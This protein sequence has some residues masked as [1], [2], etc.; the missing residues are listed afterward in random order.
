[1]G[2]ILT[3]VGYLLHLHE[4]LFSSHLVDAQIPCQYMCQRIK[5][6]VQGIS[7]LPQVQQYIL[8]DV[9]CLIGIFQIPLRCDHQ[10]GSDANHFLFEFLLCH[11]DLFYPYYVRYRD[12]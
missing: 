11:H 9:L 6:N 12:L 8:N 1:M 10:M 5:G 2:C 4:R 7:H 3:D